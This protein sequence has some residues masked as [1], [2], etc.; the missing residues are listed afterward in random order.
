MKRTK[1]TIVGTHPLLFEIRR[2]LI[3][4]KLM[5]LVDTS[6]EPNFVI[7]GA[8]KSEAESSDTVKL[9]AELNGVPKNTPVLLLSSSDVYS[10]RDDMG[11]VSVNKPMSEDRGSV[12]TSPL[13]DRA[14]RT[15]F[16]LTIE[17]MVLGS[18]PH[19]LVLRTFE[20]YG[21]Q[22]DAGTIW[23]SLAS[24]KAGNAISVEAPG[25]QTR[26]FLH[27]DDFLVAF[28]RLVP[29]FL[30]GARGLYNIGSTEEISL[31]RLAD[32]IWQLQNPQGGATPIE[33]VSP[34]GRQVWW[35]TPD[36]ARI[37]VL[38]GWKPEITLRKG[39]WTIITEG[40]HGQNYQQTGLV[41]DK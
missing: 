9:L 15:L 40:Q 6:D 34:K 37:R 12:I 21:P 5:Q 30:Q 25:Y 7:I 29:K 26:T 1:F 39:L 23:K 22:L 27:L 17:N 32:S 14:A 28:D 4:D 20:V 24:A 8:S 33:L 38:L 31:K 35:V 41:A 13:D 16:S 36:I 3:V 19:A 11:S 18:Y 2:H 10:D